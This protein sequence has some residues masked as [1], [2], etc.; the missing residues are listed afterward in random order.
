M[1]LPG[2][3]FRCAGEHLKRSDQV[4]NLDAGARHEHDAPC[5][6]RL[7]LIHRLLTF[8]LSSIGEERKKIVP[9]DNVDS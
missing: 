2:V 3:H 9:Y 5:C 8:I 1:V 7:T 6:A 4:K